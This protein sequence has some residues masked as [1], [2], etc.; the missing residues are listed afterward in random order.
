MLLLLLHWHCVAWMTLE[1]AD[2][3]EA[4]DPVK[5]NYY[6][7]VSQQFFKSNGCF[8]VSFSSDT[9]KFKRGIERERERKRE[10]ERERQTDRQIENV[11]ACVCVCV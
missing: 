1:T 5:D 9:R 4:R 7:F 2:Q 8:S 11:R 3:N 6:N 10:I